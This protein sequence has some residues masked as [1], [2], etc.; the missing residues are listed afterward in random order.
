[1][2]AD[3]LHKQNMG[4]ES[5]WSLCGCD[6]SNNG[7]QF[8]ITGSE[9]TGPGVYEVTHRVKNVITGACSNIPMVKLIHILL[10]SD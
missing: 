6:F 2:P 5:V 4:G 1:M 9:S 10:E 7:V 8:L 3:I